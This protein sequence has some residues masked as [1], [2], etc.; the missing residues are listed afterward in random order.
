MAYQEEWQAFFQILPTE[1]DKHPFGIIYL[2][3]EKLIQT[4]LLTYL[5]V[6]DYYITC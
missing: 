4:F 3:G 1:V 6:T 5:N 2:S